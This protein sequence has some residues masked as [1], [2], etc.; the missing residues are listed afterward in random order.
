MADRTPDPLI[1]GG[2]GPWPLVTV[3]E[4]RALERAAVAAG[5][6]ESALQER[7][8]LAV[9][10]CIRGLVRGRRTA[11]RVVA[12]VGIGNNGRDAV[13]AARYLREWGHQVQ[14]WLGSRHGL[15]GD[16]LADLATRDI[17]LRE[18]ATA[19][20]LVGLEDAL[21]G[22]D[23]AI[24]GLLGV[25][26]RGAARPELAAVIERVNG[27]RA[28][29]GRPL[30]VAV[31]VPSG[32]DADT[33]ELP[34][35]AICADLSVTF[36]GV[37]IGALRFPAAELVGRQELADIGIPREAVAAVPFQV[38]EP[39]LVRAAVPARP[40]NAHKYRLGRALVVAGS[41]TYLGAATLCSAAAARS[42]CGLVGVASTAAV[43]SAVA[44]Y[45][46]EA[47]YPCTVDLEHRPDEA[48]AALAPLLPDQGAL[49]VGPG[50]GRS[51]GA[52]R[53][54]RILLEHN[55]SLPRPVPCVVD[56]D[57]LSL[58]A[59]WDRWWER[60]APGTVLTPHAGE[61]ARLSGLGVAEIEADPW[62][63]GRALAERW[64]H[65]VVLKGAHTVVAAPGQ[66][67]CVYPHPNASLATAGTGDVLAGICAGLIAQGAAPADAARLAVVVH[68]E[69]GRRA[70]RSMRSLLA[71]DLLAR[72]PWALHRLAGAGRAPLTFRGR[73]SIHP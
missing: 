4:M 34:G 2:A 31:D 56:A 13:V 42:G 16:E 51:E 69:A 53:V 23:V 70:G 32:I 22:A 5:S 52:A 33:G 61:M 46:P 27:V 8:G 64:G 25:G 36:G 54:L 55:A 11:L 6:P 7:A 60:I 58:L 41:D 67:T 29:G 50:I 68:A 48:L 66:P 39:E 28:R 15:T 26:A 35:A 63:V 59:Q 38:L 40:L 9:A 19:E 43:K 44:A 20:G 17:S 47:T 3:E 65:V 57:A 14:V 62:A 12:L 73:G 1:A 37:K 24:D 21:T 45:L 30:V 49:L 72:I 71:S 18:Y 10:R